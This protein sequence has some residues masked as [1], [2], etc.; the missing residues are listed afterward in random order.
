MLLL[1]RCANLFASLHLHHPHPHA[2]YLRMKTCIFNKTVSTV[3]TLLPSRAPFSF[4]PQ[5]FGTCYSSDRDTVLFSFLPPSLPGWPLLAFIS[6]SGTVPELFLSF[7]SSQAGGPIGSAAAGRSK[8]RLQP[9]PQLT[10]I[11]QS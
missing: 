3:F 6:S 5:D 1:K 7:G 4:L 8:P 11:P 9:T 10:V 2:N